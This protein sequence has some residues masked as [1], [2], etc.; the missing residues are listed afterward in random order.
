[1]GITIGEHS[2]GTPT[3]LKW[4]ES[5]PIK[6]G[7][8]CSIA[9][10]VTIL[11]GGNHRM[12]WV[13]TFPIQMKLKNQGDP[14]GHPYTRGPITIGNDVWIGYGTCILSGVDI[15]DG[16]CIA[17]WSV[18]T[19]DVPPYAV[20]GGNPAQIIKKRFGDQEIAELLKIRWWDW[21]D[22]K[23]MKYAYLLNSPDINEFIRIT[24][25]I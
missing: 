5:T 25:D 20:T 7:R 9:G 11:A 1:M 24:R 15:G 10:N 13:S 6:V 17:A 2:Y 3:V 16:A 21:P 18:V 14:P 19:R 12:D 23:V 4:D 22:E 8:Y